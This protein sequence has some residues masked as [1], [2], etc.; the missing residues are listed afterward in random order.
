M[1]IVIDKIIDDVKLMSLVLSQLRLKTLLQIHHKRLFY[2]W[3]YDLHT[4]RYDVLH[5]RAYRIQGFRVWPILLQQFW[6]NLSFCVSRPYAV[7]KWQSGS[8]LNSHN[9]FPVAAPLEL[10]NNKWIVTIWWKSISVTP[11]SMLTVS[12]LLTRNWW[13]VSS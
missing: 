3:E 4:Y 10:F 9:A 11:V 2:K 1:V 6:H 7:L 8:N 12:W 13:L 5:Y